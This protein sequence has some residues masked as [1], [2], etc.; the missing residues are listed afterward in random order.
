MGAASVGAAT[1]PVALSGPA[2]ATTTSAP[3]PVEGSVDD[4]SYTA[5]SSNVAAG[6]TV[7]GYSGQSTDLE[8][9]SSVLLNG[10]RYAVKAIGDYSFN[11]RGLA[12]VVIPN[13]VTTIGTS[14]FADN[15]LLTV[16][17]PASVRAIGAG[18]FAF[19]YLQSVVMLGAAPTIVAAGEN[20]SF[21][22]AGDL[23]VFCLGNLAAGYAP[24]SWNGYTVT[25]VLFDPTLTISGTTKVGET[26]TAVTGTWDP[27]P[28]ITYE[29]K[30]STGGDIL[31]TSSS[32]VPTA[33]DR[34]QKL[35]VSATV[36]LAGVQGLPGSLGQGTSFAKLT[37]PESASIGY[38]VFSLTPVPTIAG[39]KQVGQSLTAISGSWSP[40]ATFTY[41]WKR[42]G[43]NTVVGTGIRYNLT[44]LDNA[45]TLT[46]TV[47]GASEGFTSVS[48]TSVATSAVATGTFLSAPKP[49]ITGT[50]TNG[51]VLTAVTTG[52]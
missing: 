14:A 43:S 17:L 40:G 25:A 28:T 3:N 30:W 32:Y 33:S 9:P 19:N 6:A 10:T 42:G 4:I 8:I 24:P 20:G 35:T 39:T 27:E 46:V 22:S 45:A 41:A 13:T 52:W 2:V 1:R 51:S 48:K 18:A 7:I 34:G 21:G 15:Q 26:L 31:G 16:S 50:A 12:S 38:G 29:W 36:S 47:T 49:T 44:A 11:E 23:S 5:D 37:S